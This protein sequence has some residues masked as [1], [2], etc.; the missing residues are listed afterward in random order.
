MIIFFDGNCPLCFKEMRALKRHDQKNTIHLVD[1][2]DSEAMLQFPEIDKARALRVLHG[3][4][5][6]QLFLGL[7][8]T[9]RAWSIVGKHRWLRMTR[10]PLIRL[11]SDRFYLLF[12]K[13]RMKISAIFFKTQCST[14][15]CGTEKQ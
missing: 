6:D 14:S 3:I 10:L 9:V 15:I 8:V 4:D 13:H 7:D 2:H 12:A 1:L 11:I 5:N